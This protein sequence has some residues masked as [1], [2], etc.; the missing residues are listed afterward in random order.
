MKRRARP[1]VQYIVFL[2]FSVNF[3]KKM[4]HCNMCSLELLQSMAG[5]FNMSLFAGRP[6]LLQA[7][8]S[9]VRIPGR[10]TDFLF[11]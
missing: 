5:C 9:W 4:W 11:S 2:L 1:I 6:D 8:Q 10:A 7:G 3:H